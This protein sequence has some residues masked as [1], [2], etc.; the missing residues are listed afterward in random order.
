MKFTIDRAV[1]NRSATL[2]SQASFRLGAECVLCEANSNHLTIRG[3]NSHSVCQVTVN[4]SSVSDGAA[5]FKAP[6]LRRALRSLTEPQVTVTV[7]DTGLCTVDDGRNEQ[8]F[9]TFASPWFPLAHSMPGS[10]VGVDL[11]SF[12][13]ALERTSTAAS[14][15]S[16]RPALM[17]VLLS[18]ENNQV[19][20]VGTDGYRVAVDNFVAPDIL[21]GHSQALVPAATIQTLLAA[22]LVKQLRKT[23]GSILWVTFDWSPLRVGF[24]AATP[25]GEAVHIT[26]TLIEATFPT[27]E[28]LQETID[29][30]PTPLTTVEVQSAELVKAVTGLRRAAR[31]ADGKANLM[32]TVRLSPN[33]TELTVSLFDDSYNVP[34]TTVDATVTATGAASAPATVLLNSRYLLDALNGFRYPGDVATTKTGA[35][36]LVRFSYTKP[37]VDTARPQPMAV[38]PA[39]DNHPPTLTCGTMHLLMPMQP[40]Q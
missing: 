38:R 10:W 33:E 28:R 25:N 37:A 3:G 32:P 26:D 16:A 34:S 21:D 24:Q 27:L 22:P 40:T 30:M 39:T 15:D 36:Q 13:A 6:D 17:G 7:D 12:C 29:D 2:A 20:A 31:Q 11:P 5:V 35:G 9:H 19:Q 14:T 18:W 23:T 4:A 1:L 8:Q